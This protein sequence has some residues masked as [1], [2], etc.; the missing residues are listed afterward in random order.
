MARAY[1]FTM[2]E[3]VGHIDTIVDRYYMLTRDTALTMP[4]LCSSLQMISSNLFCIPSESF[5][6]RVDLGDK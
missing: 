5:I 1:L 4:P 2:D 6:V 3:V